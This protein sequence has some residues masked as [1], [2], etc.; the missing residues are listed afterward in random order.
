MVDT[1][2]LRGAASAL[3]VTVSISGRVRMKRYVTLVTTCEV[4][5]VARDR[6]PF[7]YHQCGLK[8]GSRGLKNHEIQLSVKKMNHYSMLTEIPDKPL[9]EEDIT[10]HLGRILD[11]QIIIN[12]ISRWVPY[13][14]INTN[15]SRLSTLST[16]L[17]FHL[18]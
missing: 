2:A 11:N 7:D 3:P 1:N 18:N 16:C 17:L 15:F 12:W 9:M 13:Q 5:E 6:F 14:Y 10:K 8:I 4:T